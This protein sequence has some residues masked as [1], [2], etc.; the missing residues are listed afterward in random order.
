MSCCGRAVTVDLRSRCDDGLWFCMLT[1]IGFIALGSVLGMFLPFPAFA[2]TAIVCSIAYSFYHFD[3]TILRCI[4]DL[5]T[6]V[7]ALQLG[8]FFSVI[9]TILHRRRRFHR[10]ND[11]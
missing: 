1:V 9:T 4:S 7:L 11:R 2:L 3:G 10:R 8:Y 6:A 5:L